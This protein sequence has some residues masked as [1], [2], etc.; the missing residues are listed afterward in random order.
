MFLLTLKELYDDY[1][2][3][4]LAE[5]LNKILKEKKIKVSKQSV[6][7]W[8]NDECV[9]KLIIQEAIIFFYKENKKREKLENLWSIYKRNLDNSFKKVN[10]DNNDG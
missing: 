3:T 7:N 9:P 8:V 10:K 1:G 5:K 2:A 4:K 6:S